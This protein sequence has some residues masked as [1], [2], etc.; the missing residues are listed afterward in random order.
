MLGERERRGGGESKDVV[1]QSSVGHLP[2]AYSSDQS[3]VEG[4]WS[5][6]LEH[7]INPLLEANSE[8]KLHALVC[9]GIEGGRLWVGGEKGK[10][11]VIEVSAH[12]RM[13]HKIYL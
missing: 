13:K 9:W 2:D 11:T 10:Q 12:P 3:H 6:G 5:P 8:S 7:E 4:V 1:K